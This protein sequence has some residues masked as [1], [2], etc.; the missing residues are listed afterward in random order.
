MDERDSLLDATQYTLHNLQTVARSQRVQDLSSLTLPEIDEIVDKI[1]RIAPAGNVPG[2][3]LSSLLRLPQQIPSVEIVRRDIMLLFK[4]V[5][6]TLID[7]AVYRTFYWTPA[8]IL[9]A[10]QQLLK[11]AGK[12][13]EMSFPEGTWQ[14]YVDYALRDDTARHTCETHGFDSTLAQHQLRLSPVDRLTAW[15]MAA[16]YCLHQY[17]DLLENE[18]R[19]RVTIYILQELTA[20]HPDAAHFQ[21][22]YRLWD[23]KRPYSRGQDVQPHEDYPAYRRRKFDEFLAVAV[24]G[25]PKSLVAEWRARSQQAEKNDLLAYQQ[26][27]SIRSYLEPS[28]YGEVRKPVPLASAHVGII[29]QGRYYLLPIC[30]ENSAAAADVVAMRTRIATLMAHPAENPPAQLH[31]LAYVKRAALAEIR[32]ELP[33][34]LISELD[35]LRL[36]PIWIN[37]DRRSRHLPLSAIRQGERGIGDHPL[38]IFDTGETFVFDL[39]HI[40]FDGVWGVAL[41]EIITNEALSWAVHLSSMP[42]SQPG[43]KRPY[44]PA[45]HVRPPDQKR[46]DDA[47]Q[48]AMEASAES[49]SVDVPA[50]LSLRELFKQRS[51]LLGMTVNDLLMIYRVIHAAIYRPSQELTERLERLKTEKDPETVTAAELALTAVRANITRNPAILI[52]VDASKKSPRD[53]VYPMTLDIPVAQLDVI[54]LHQKALAAL[55]AYERALRNREHVYAQF[56]KLQKEYL[57]TLAGFGEWLSQ[58]KQRAAAGESVSMDTIRLLANLPVQVQRFL[59]R[60]PGQFDVLNDLL[61][62]REVFSNVGQVA[63]TSSLTRFMTAKD[64]NE[65]KELVWGLMTDAEQVMQITL[66]DFR[67]HVRLLTAVGRPDLSILIATDILESYATGLNQYVRDVHRITAAQYKQ[68]GLFSRS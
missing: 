51:D 24:D 33:G 23:G 15:A 39:S 63:V 32:E 55:T 65:K 13:P 3:I 8:A 41:A 42:A 43:Q 40:Y 19:E 56:E 11:L 60:I 18:W 4:G 26:Q 29:H 37:T 58:R 68:R 1:A 30:G 49:R 17:Y 38:T 47:P 34:G 36:A 28:V 44:S 46:F 62:G 53:R 20:V 64:D 35:G 61:K 10:Y 25:L 14:F 9:S 52:P 27:M 45:L 12:D 2:V 66:R 7:K 22:L 54:G 6:Q 59:D 21:R 31:K 5:E 48:V 16:A 50:I 57:S 67:P